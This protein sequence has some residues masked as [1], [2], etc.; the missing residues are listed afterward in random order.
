MSRLV[1]SAKKKNYQKEIR[2][3]RGK[4]DEKKKKKEK[5]EESVKFLFV[6]QKRIQVQKKIFLRNTLIYY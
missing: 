3:E 4:Y 5:R 2:N 1:M 6:L